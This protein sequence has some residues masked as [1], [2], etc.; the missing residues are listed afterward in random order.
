VEVDLRKIGWVPPAH[1]SNQAF[2]KDFSIGKLVSLDENTKLVFLTEGVIVA[3]HT[4]QEGSDWRTAARVM[5]AFFIQVKDGT[6]FSTMRWPTR[7]RRSD[8]D[9]RDSEARLIPLSNG[10]FLTLANG[11]LRLYASNLDLLKEQKLEPDTSGDM[12]AAQSVAEG[13]KIF[14]RHESISPPN[15]T[16][17]WVDSENLK[18]MHTA[19]GY[20]DRDFLVQAGVKAGDGSVFT[21]SKSGVRM[22]DKDQNV[23]TIC[24]DRL[25]RDA[26]LFHVLSARRIGVSA[27]N[28]FGIIDIDDGIMWSKLIDSKYDPK[29]F[30]FG[31]IQCALSGTRLGL[32][33]TGDKKA[34]FDGVKVST[35]PPTILVYDTDGPKNPFVIR[36]TP[37]DGQLDFS[38]S[39]NG[40][41]VAVF[42]GAKVLIYEM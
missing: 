40:T 30:Q 10:R 18:I 20:R 21:L 17:S 2:F 33:L 6:L 1:Q 25:C 35:W 34:F 37:V 38:L 11:V 28:G 31:S 32:W 5:E 39:P 9:D 22:I 14:L 41:K 16:Y 24:G 26:D 8:N 42:D 4:K 3:Y 27:R 15:T 36:T 19:P 23:K 12:W 13:Q 29:R 7:L